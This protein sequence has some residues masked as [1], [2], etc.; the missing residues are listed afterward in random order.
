MCGTEDETRR[1]DAIQ[2]HGAASNTRNI[3]GEAEAYCGEA[4]NIRLRSV[5]E[6]AYTHIYAMVAKS[7]PFIV[8]NTRYRENS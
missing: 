5:C 1:A 3:H 2:L 7:F 6:L 4:V 8:P